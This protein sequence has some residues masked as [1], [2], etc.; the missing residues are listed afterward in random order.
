MLWSTAGQSISYLERRSA[1]T[2]QAF[3]TDRKPRSISMK[4]FANLGVKS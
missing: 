4:I 1:K 2:K 3:K